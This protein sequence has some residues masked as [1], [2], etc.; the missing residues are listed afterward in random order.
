MKTTI[1]FVTATLSLISSILLS[2]SGI[3]VS[4]FSFSQTHN[5][6]I[7]TKIKPVLSSASKSTLFSSSSSTENS[8]II[9]NL[10]DKLLESI[11]I[12]REIQER[13]GDISIDF[14]VKGGELNATTRAPQKLD[15]YRVSK[16][17]GQTCDGILETC[18]QLSKL[19]PNPNPT[20]FFNDLQFGST[21]SLLHGEW[22]LLFTTAAD[23]TFSKNSTRGDAKVSNIVDA[24]T[25]KIQNCIQ[26]LS[27]DNTPPIVKSFN[28]F[29]KATT[30]A[31]NRINLVFR[32]VRIDLT[33][34]FFLPISWS[35]FIPVPGPFITKFIIIL[36]KLLFWKKQKSVTEVPQAYFDILYLD[37]QLRIHKTG[38]DNL[39]IQVKAENW[40]EAKR[41][42]K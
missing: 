35:L 2:D 13:D 25:G 1:P 37:H 5:R 19:T 23:A 32:Y 38:E 27:K 33:K 26:F 16:E 29:L 40:D 30:S 7:H 15:Y 28:A 31:P 9:D 4:A 12:L 22:K 3:T 20:D 41:L 24:S 14:G 36:N 34:L 42:L 6:K 18:T 10:K 8:N 39:F 11:Q 21:K 17:A